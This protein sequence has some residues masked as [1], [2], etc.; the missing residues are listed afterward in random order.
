M[1]IIHVP[2]ISS[3]HN[4]ATSSTP[5]W[6]G[7]GFPDPSVHQRTLR[8]AERWPLSSRWLRG[9]SLCI[10][11]PT[12]H[13]PLWKCQV[14]HYNELSH[15][16]APSPPPREGNPCRPLKSTLL[17]TKTLRPSQGAR[18][19]WGQGRGGV[20]PPNTELLRRTR[21]TSFWTLQKKDLA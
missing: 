19:R 7:C 13:R 1:P 20:S 6:W 10:G 21:R 18:M 16:G 14:Q 4:N 11:L 12:P 9:E 8:Q 2:Q 3:D 15:R 17:I 5:R